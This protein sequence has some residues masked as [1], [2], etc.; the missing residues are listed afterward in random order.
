MCPA[1]GHPPPPSVHEKYAKFYFDAKH[2]KRDWIGGA[3][4]FCTL[5]LPISDT[6]LIL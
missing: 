1:V 4:I 5:S 3:E 2:L 6:A